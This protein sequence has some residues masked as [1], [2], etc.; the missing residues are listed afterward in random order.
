M[1][2]L[3]EIDPLIAAGVVAATLVSDAVSVLYTASVAHRRDYSAA[4]WG[5]MTYMLS[6]YAVISFTS[7][8]GYVLFAA[9]GSWIGAFATMRYL[10]WHSARAAGLETP[11]SPAVT[12]DAAPAITLPESLPASLDGTPPPSPFAPGPRLAA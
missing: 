2:L 3:V 5:A 11:A 9:L 8:W 1:Q 7:N 4:T 6:A 12:A 10:R